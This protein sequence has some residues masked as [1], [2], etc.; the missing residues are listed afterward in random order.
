MPVMGPTPPD[1]KK[2]TGGK[3]S[4]QRWGPSDWAP[5][6]TAGVGAL[7]GLLAFFGTLSGDLP[8]LQRNGGF[9]VGL[10]GVFFIAG[11]VLLGYFFWLRMSDPPPTNEPAAAQERKREPS[12]E[13][14]NAEVR[15]RHA[16]G[17]RHAPPE[18]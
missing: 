13:H 2:S 12:P 17:T 18:E 11:F 8:R 1:E 16:S 15:G 7:G 5:M 10:A 6:V 9:A 14:Q 4:G 3:A